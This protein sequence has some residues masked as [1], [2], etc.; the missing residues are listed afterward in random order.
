MCF[1]W[2]Q[3]ED[4]A[5]HHRTDLRGDPQRGG[6][7]HAALLGAPERHLSGRFRPF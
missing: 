4:G 1:E 2:L 7:P 3:G 6:G 5:A